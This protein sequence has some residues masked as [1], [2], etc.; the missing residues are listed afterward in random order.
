MGSAPKERVTAAKVVTVEARDRTPREKEVTFRSLNE[1]AIA[2]ARRGT[3]PLTAQ[4]RR[5][6]ARLSNRTDKVAPR[7]P[8]A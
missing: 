8:R 4:K 5:T 1:I 3:W 7:Q 6:R 2:A